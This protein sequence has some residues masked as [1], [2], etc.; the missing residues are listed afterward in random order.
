MRPVR[1]VRKR[2]ISPVVSSHCVVPMNLQVN[3]GTSDDASFNTTASEESDMG[4]QAA[5]AQ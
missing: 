2:Y 3:P 5:S 1:R 4:M